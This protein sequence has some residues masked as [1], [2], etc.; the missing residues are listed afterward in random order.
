MSRDMAVHEP[1]G[2]AGADADI[3]RAMEVP[4]THPLRIDTGVPC[5][6]RG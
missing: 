5:P 4:A 3:V 1:G 6:K 2:A